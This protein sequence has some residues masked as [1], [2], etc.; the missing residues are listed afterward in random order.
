M[1]NKANQ[2]IVASLLGI[3][4]LLGTIFIFFYTKKSITEKSTKIE[5]TSSD[6]LK[7]NNNAEDAYFILDAFSELNQW[8]TLTSRNGNISFKYP[9][10]LFKARKNYETPAS[11]LSFD[12]ETKEDWLTQTIDSPL[13]NQCNDL[14]DFDCFLWNWPQRY[15]LYLKAINNKAS[16]NFGYETL[17]V[18]EKTKRINGVDWL[19]GVNLGI[20]GG[21]TV[22]Y[23]SYIKDTEIHFYADV[24]DDKFFKTYHHEDLHDDA[25]LKNP[26]VMD[27]ADKILNDNATD[28][29]TQIK[30]IAIEKTIKTIVTKN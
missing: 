11:G 25:Y 1:T 21:C 22:D 12:M 30:Q 3:V 23:I 27:W 14:G 4:L 5:Q 20:N 18:K 13:D 10:S 29:S 16:F 9:P 17:L 24:C 15:N 28:F 8:T 2:I 6:F 26:M 7:N 19:V